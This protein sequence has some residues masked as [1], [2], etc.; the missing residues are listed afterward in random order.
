MI[1]ARRAHRDDLQVG[2]ARADAVGEA[3]EPDHRDLVALE[4]FDEIVLS[5][6]SAVGTELGAG[7]FGGQLG[8][9]LGKKSK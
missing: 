3:V 8:L 7:I 6:P 5:E 2:Q 1:D 9:E 4:K